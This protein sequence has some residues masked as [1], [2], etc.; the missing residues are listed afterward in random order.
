MATDPSGSIF[1]YERVVFH[2]RQLIEA[3]HLKPGDKVPSIRKIGQQLGIGH[4]TAVHGYSLLEAQ[5]VIEAIPKSGFY[6]CYQEDV[7]FSSPETSHP[8]MDPTFVS[9]KQLISNIAQTSGNPDFIEFGLAA[10]SPELLPVKALKKLTASV[11][12]NANL[13]QFTYDM[14]PGDLLLR[15]EIAKLSQSWGGAIPPEEVLITNG[16]VEA[17]HICLRAVAKPGDTIAIESPAFYAFLQI[18]DN[19]GMYAIE[20]PTDPKT[21]LNVEAYEEILQTHSIQACL[22][23]A[24]FSNPTGATMPEENKK[25]LVRLSAQ[26]GV[27][28]IEDDVYGDLYFDRYRP[29]PLKAYDT[30]GLVLHCSSFSKTI[31][32]GYRIGYAMAGRYQEAVQRIRYMTSISPPPLSEQVIAQCL[33]KGL[34]HKWTKQLRLKL[35]EQLN[36]HLRV[37]QQH[38]PPGVKV[39]R[40][41][42]GFLLWLQF[43][44]AI[45]AIT[46]FEEAYK[47]QI[48]IAPG[49]MFSPKDGAFT[50]YIRLSFSNPWS[51]AIEDGLKTLGS[52]LR[53]QLD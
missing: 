37:I 47:Q 6:V 24:N 18:L 41:E 43:P 31:C 28:I 53:Q 46:L 10:L 42:G 32:P 11:V 15:Q 9:V 23:M 44:K 20:V 3:G 22:M 5:G 29:R 26:A 52:L 51:S 12:R 38:F 34:Y 14:P 4:M 36:Q 39:N 25:K 19:L 45:N 8:S 2:I 21:G 48:S 17:L 27:P 35:Q 1:L 13:Q 7:S 16:A 33:N 40:P 50:H 30:K 49:P